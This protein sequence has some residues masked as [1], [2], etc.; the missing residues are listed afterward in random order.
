MGHWIGISEVKFLKAIMLN[1]SFCLSWFGLVEKDSAISGVSFILL[2]RL[3]FQIG[4]IFFLL[5]WL[6]LNAFELFFCS[7]SVEC[8]ID[9]I[10]GLFC[11]YSHW[12]ICFTVCLLKFLLMWL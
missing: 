2:L 11:V 6:F 1:R 3:M 8:L 5:L 9:E 4:L 7:A 10:R 12:I